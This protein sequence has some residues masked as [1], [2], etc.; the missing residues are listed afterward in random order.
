MK[1]NKLI[2]T[3]QTYLINLIYLD[4]KKREL[5][6]TKYIVFD[7]LMKILPLG[8]ARQLSASDIIRHTAHADIQSIHNALKWLAE[9]GYIMRTRNRSNEKYYYQWP[10][11][12]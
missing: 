7:V 3:Y 6:K 4:Q 11:A 5:Q 10:K 1:Q 8:E 12:S 2:R 9:N